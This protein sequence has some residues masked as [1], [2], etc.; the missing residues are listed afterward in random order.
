MASASPKET[1]LESA[2]VPL[3]P[4]HIDEDD[5]ASLYALQCHG[6]YV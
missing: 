5:D 3:L 4:K 1:L 6:N 2:A